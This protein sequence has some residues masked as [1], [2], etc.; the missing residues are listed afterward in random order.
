M[1]I[2]AIYRYDQFGHYDKTFKGMY[3]QDVAKVY[4]AQEYEGVIKAIDSFKAELAQVSKSIDAANTSRH[5][6]YEYLKP[7]N[8]IN[9]IS[10]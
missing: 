5:V 6:K 3:N 2:L 7:E 1:Y 4:E 8:I 10:V 9:S